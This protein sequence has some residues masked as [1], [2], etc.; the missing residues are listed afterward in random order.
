MVQQQTLTALG[1]RERKADALERVVGDAR[2]GADFSLPGMLHAK[3]LRS[4]HA[5]ARIRRIDYARALGVPGVVAVV[6]AGDLRPGQ[7]GAAH[8]APAEAYDPGHEEEH[9]AGSRPNA[10]RTVFAGAKALWAGQPV[11]AVAA[12]T[13]QAAEEALGL[14]E[15]SYEVLPMMENAE[16]SM[17]PGAPLLHPN[18]FTTTLGVNAD[19]PSNI[20]TYVELVRGDVERGFREADVVIED[21]YRTRMIHQGYLEPRATLAKVDPDGKLT[22]WVSS[23]GIFAVQQQVAEVLN[24]PPHRVRIIPTEFGGGFGSKGQGLLEPLAALLAVK[25]GRPVKMVMGRDEEFKAGRPGSPS[26]AWVKMGVKRDGTITAAQIRVIMD[27]GAY[28]G[29]PVGAATNLSFGVYKVPNLRVEGYDVVTNKPPV[30]AYRAPGA[31][32]AAYAVEQHM[33]RL[34]RA[35]GMDPLELRLKNIA[36]EGDRMPNDTPLPRVGFRTT[37]ETVKRHPIWGHRPSK[38]NQGRGIACGMWM[39]GLQPNS[40]FLKLNGDGSLGLEVGTMDITGTRTAFKQMVASEFQVPT[41]RVAVTTLDT[42]TAP[43]ASN[44]GG[45]KTTNTMGSAIKQASDNLK[46]QLQSR[47]ASLLDLPQD[48]VGYRAGLFHSLRDPNRT[49]S[50]QDLGARS[51]AAGGGPVLASGSAGTFKAAPSFAAH[52]VDVEVDPET[53]K[54]TLLGYHAFQDCGFAVNPT[55]VEGQM[56]GGVA[57]GIG[58]ALTEEYV[59]GDGVMRNPTFLDYRMPTSLDL[60]LI[61]PTIVQVPNP[62]S[63]YGVRGVGEVPLVPPMAAIAN[64]IYDATGARITELPMSPE[65]VFWALHRKS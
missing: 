52:V 10:S 55:Q 61:E 17:Q 2:Y 19:T 32:Q 65:R 46:R 56:Q 6:T 57:Q 40:C 12:T 30:G 15:V 18:L 33:D 54:V 53:G 29:G 16:Q 26:V 64:A 1:Q 58:W 22:I 38:P 9:A 4:P 37:L 31:P 47:A 62:D 28:P 45:S 39:G 7:A 43:Y 23:Q 8:D 41:E 59:F 27:S 13:L 21:T 25:T 5:H 3:I 44:S 51:V 24:L 36:G 50:L 14:I 60:P 63:P 49:V 20:S 34:A 11:A 35:L 42:D 48:Q